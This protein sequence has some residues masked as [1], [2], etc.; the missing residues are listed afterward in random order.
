MGELEILCLVK[1]LTR[2]MHRWFPG[3]P[4]MYSKVFKIRHKFEISPLAKVQ[5][6]T[7]RQKM[8]PAQLISDQPPTLL[9][10]NSIKDCRRIRSLAK[11]IARNLWSEFARFVLVTSKVGRNDLASDSIG[12]SGSAVWMLYGLKAELKHSHCWLC[13]FTVHSLKS[14]GAVQ[15]SNLFREER[16]CWH[17]G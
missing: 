7:T 14:K 11:V 3:M 12:L 5:G 13:Y 2:R 8:V 1:V 9:D 17:L 6:C 4:I 15:V 16:T 10:N